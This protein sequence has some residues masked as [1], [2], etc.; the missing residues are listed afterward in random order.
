MIFWLG[1]FVPPDIDSTGGGSV[2]SAVLINLGILILWSIQHSGMAR[3]SW[4]QK[5][6][7]IIPEHL[8]RSIYV[9]ISGILCIGIVFAWQPLP[10]QVWRASEGSAL[11]YFLYAGFFL[12]IGVLLF[13]TFLIN[14]F[15][16]FGLQ[17]TFF[18]MLGKTEKV[19]QFKDTILYKIVR[20]PIYLGFMMI[21]WFVPS[22]SMTHFALSIGFTAYIYLGIYF[23]E[24]DL[25]AEY[26]QKYLEYRKRI[27]AL[28][29]FVKVSR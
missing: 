10:G 3:K 26:G 24:K 19:A 16:L 4:K 9:L 17:Q 8:Q 25:V 18:K 11:Q 29:P 20:H 2:A 6:K 5:T 15:Q 13:S 28:I 21:I 7:N 1:G 14:H 12:G 27:P 22:M 23:E